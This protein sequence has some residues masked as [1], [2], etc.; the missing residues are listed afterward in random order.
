MSDFEYPP[1]LGWCTIHA[2]TTVCKDCEI[3]RLQKENEEL[4]TRL[5][6]RTYFHDN[7]AVE[8]E[9]E[10]LKRKDSIR[11]ELWQ[12]TL[13][14]I[15]ALREEKLLCLR[16]GYFKIKSNDEHCPA[17]EL[18]AD[19]VVMAREIDEFG[20]TLSETVKKYLPKEEP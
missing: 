19:C 5:K 12:A 17:C 10:A 6:G 3:D 13:K 2:S 8:A 4:K 11:E 9:N 20:C 16:H 15:E 1:R 7:A 18:E 14:E